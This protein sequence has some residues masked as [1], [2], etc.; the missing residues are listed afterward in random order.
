VAEGNAAIHA[1]R[2]LRAQLLLVHVL[3]E[4]LPDADA[5]DWRAVNGQFAQVFDKSC[6]LSHLMK[7]I[8]NR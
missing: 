2:A 7:K 1:A 4:F 3:V 8:F 5:R 6:W